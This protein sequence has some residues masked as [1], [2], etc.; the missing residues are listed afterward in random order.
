[1]FILHQPSTANAVIRFYV[2]EFVWMILVTTVEYRLFRRLTVR[3]AIAYLTNPKSKWLSIAKSYLESFAGF[4]G[5]GALLSLA[6]VAV[7]ADSSS[8]HSSARATDL[9]SVGSKAFVF[10]GLTEVV[11]LLVCI[12]LVCDLQHCQT[13]G[14][15]QA[16]CCCLLNQKC[17]I[18]RPDIGWP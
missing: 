10:A 15:G 5:G 4:W 13:K 17:E 9:K 8:L 11:L 14:L 1:M 3:W 18:H 7:K 2:R 12:R 16:I 6:R